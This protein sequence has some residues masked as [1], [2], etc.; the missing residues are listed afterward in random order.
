[1]I[2]KIEYLSRFDSN[3]TTKANNHICEERNLLLIVFTVKQIYDSI[4][5]IA[6]GAFLLEGKYFYKE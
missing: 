4:L 6:N 1:M 5:M 2:E 3:E